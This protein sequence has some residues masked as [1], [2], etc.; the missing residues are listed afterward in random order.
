M[1]TIIDMESPL[2][3]AVKYSINQ[4]QKLVRYLKAPDIPM[5][6]NIAENAIR[7]FAQEMGY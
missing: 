2:G 1:Q 4:Y 5:D 7:P 3:K 6:Y